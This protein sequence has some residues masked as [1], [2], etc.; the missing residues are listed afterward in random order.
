MGSGHQKDAL[1][2]KK[3]YTKPE[4]KQVSLKPEEAVL[5]GCKVTEVNT[6]NVGMGYT[7]STPV[8]CSAI[9]S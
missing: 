8:P 2:P 7:C 6:P 9:A 5:G 3:S 4:V 1:L